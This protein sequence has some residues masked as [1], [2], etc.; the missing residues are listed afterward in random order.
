[1][2]I[3]ASIT[4]KE[5]L[6]KKYNETIKNEAKNEAKK[7][8]KYKQNKII[9]DKYMTKLI[10]SFV[11]NQLYEYFKLYITQY[12]IHHNINN[13]N[14]NNNIFYFDCPAIMIIF[15]QYYSDMTYTIKFINKPNIIYKNTKTVSIKEKDF[16]NEYRNT[17]S[18]IIE[19]IMNEFINKIKN[20][21]NIINI[22]ITKLHNFSI[23]F[24]FNKS[25]EIIDLP[26]PYIES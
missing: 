1:M 24:D 12:R 6:D 23:A 11:D 26:P 19:K 8:L 17:N 21:V 7:M 15:N 16:S 20:E 25:S 3:S 22:S 9:Y 18:E 14:E 13:L 2:G 10:K 5:D 4:L